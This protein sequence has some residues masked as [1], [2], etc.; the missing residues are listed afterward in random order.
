MLLGLL[1]HDGNSLLKKFEFDTTTKFFSLFPF[2]CIVDLDTGK[3]NINEFDTKQLKNRRELLVLP[4]NLL[5]Q[6][7]ILSF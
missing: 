5:L 1:T 7:W 4:Y 3:M 2:S 6:V